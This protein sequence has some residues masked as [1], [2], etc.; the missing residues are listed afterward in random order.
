MAGL[1]ANPGFL[2]TGEI[3]MLRRVNPEAPVTPALWRLLEQT[4]QLDAPGWAS[5]DDWERRWGLLALCMAYVPGLHDY[6][7]PLGQ[8][9]ATAGWSEMRFVRLM[10]AGADALPPLMRRMAQYL[11]SKE[12]SANWDDARRLIFSL[13]APHANDVR[14]TIARS[15]YRALYAQ[16]QDD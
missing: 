12:Q 9:L 7:V 5:Q 6:N 8:A 15:Y 4:D 3:A 10:E 2:S 11:A 1:L 14:L 13:G 16:E